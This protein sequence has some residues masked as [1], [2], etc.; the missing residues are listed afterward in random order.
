MQLECA[1]VVIFVV[2]IG[3][4]WLAKNSKPSV[5]EGD[6]GF[7]VVSQLGWVGSRPKQNWYGYTSQGS[8]P[9]GQIVY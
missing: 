9:L 3:A 7:G 6:S 1:I 8:S 4:V 5:R 2:V